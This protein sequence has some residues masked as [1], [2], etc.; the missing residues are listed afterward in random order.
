MF[1]FGAYA[2]ELN[3]GF[4]F[5]QINVEKASLLPNSLEVW[6]LINTRQ[7]RTKFISTREH[8]NLE[9]T[10]LHVKEKEGGLSFTIL[11]YTLNCF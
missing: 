9:D 8:F 11:L 7:L 10:N 3:V 5:P 6:P 2:N 4:F 1:H